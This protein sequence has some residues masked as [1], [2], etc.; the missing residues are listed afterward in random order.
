[1]N[2]G[3]GTNGVVKG[4]GACFEITWLKIMTRWRPSGYGVEWGREKWTRYNNQLHKGSH[5]FLTTTSSY[6]ADTSHKGG[7]L[8]EYAFVRETRLHFFFIKLLRYFTSKLAK[9]FCRT[10]HQCEA[11]NL[12]YNLIE[13]K[14]KYVDYYRRYEFFCWCR[15]QICR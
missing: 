3:T 15:C 10:M 5:P 13:S 2:A 9:L 1:M 7:L 14:V 11:R 4:K 6:S 8:E 12:L